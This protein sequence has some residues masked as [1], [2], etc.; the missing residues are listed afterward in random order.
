MRRFGAQVTVVEQGKQLAGREDPDGSAAILDLFR[1]EG[2]DV[3]LQAQLQSV[4]GAS[5]SAVRV[6]T[7]GSDGERLIEASD[8]LVGVGR[9]PNTSGVGLGQAGV[10]LT[11]TGYIAVDERLAT[12]AT[13]VWAMGECAGS[14][15]FTHVAFD[16]FR[17]VYDNLH[18]GSSSTAGRLVPFC[19]FTRP[20]FARVGLGEAVASYLGIDYRP[21]TLPMAT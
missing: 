16:D 19:M 14:P 11:D 21:I 7:Q 5:G 9:T 8:L 1:D 17:V 18:G 4:E 2:I 15:Q 12:T 6:V 10:K 20:A 13:N 3:L